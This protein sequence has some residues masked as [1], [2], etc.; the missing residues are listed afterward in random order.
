MFKTRY[1]ARNRKSSQ[2]Y[3]KHNKK[4]ISLKG[5]LLA[6]SKEDKNQYII[7]LLER[8]QVYEFIHFFSY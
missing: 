8:S 3:K 5:S 1:I 4:N 2:E 6:K 7:S